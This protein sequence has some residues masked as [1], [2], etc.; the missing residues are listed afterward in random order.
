MG[1][2]NCDG[3][4]QG[5]GELVGCGRLFQQPDG[6]WIK[7]FSCKVGVYDALHDEVWGLYIELDM[8][9]REGLS[10]LIVE[11]DS[12]VLV[13]MV[14][15]NYKI[16]GVIRSLIR[17]IQKLLRRDWHTQVIHTWLEGNKCAD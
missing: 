11:R 8:A 9:S 12:K 10:H 16:N 13:N 1:E 6:K 14:T 17:Y 3:A 5:N 2:I 15:T 7:G 4:F